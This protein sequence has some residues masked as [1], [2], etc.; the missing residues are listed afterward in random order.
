MLDFAPADM[1]HRM[2]TDSRTRRH[3][4]RAK[5]KNQRAPPDSLLFARLFVATSRHHLAQHVNLSTEESTTCSFGAVGQLKLASILYCRGIAAS[6]QPRH[7]DQHVLPA[8]RSDQIIL[9]RPMSSYL[10][11]SSYRLGHIDS[12]RWTRSLLARLTC[13]VQSLLPF[14]RLPKSV[15]VHLKQTHRYSNHLQ[16]CHRGPSLYSLSSHQT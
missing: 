7:E 1:L 3:G 14:H 8:A 10:S 16:N 12:F 9:S 5:K 13:S 11:A 2:Q 4:S 15:Y 6:S